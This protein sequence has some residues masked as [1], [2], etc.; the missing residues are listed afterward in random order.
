MYLLRVLIGSLGNLGLLRLA[1]GNYFGFGFTTLIR[2]PLYLVIYLLI[3]LDTIQTIAVPPT[4]REVMMLLSEYREVTTCYGFTSAQRQLS[5]K[6]RAPES[7][8]LT[9][10]LSTLFKNPPF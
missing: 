10:S 4:V 1:G 5:T 6:V 3:F 7:P 2:K 8:N 9:H